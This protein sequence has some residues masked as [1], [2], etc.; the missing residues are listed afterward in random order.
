MIKQVA[1]VLLLGL[2]LT[3][4]KHELPLV[5]GAPPNVTPPTPGSNTICFQSSVL[6]IFVSN[7]AKSGCHDAASHEEGIV[8]DNYAGI[9]RG[10][11]ANDAAN[12]KYWKVIITLN[13]GDRMPPPPASPLSTAQKDSIYKW[14]MQGAQNTT[15]CTT[16]CDTAQFAYTSTIKPILQTNC[17][18]CHG[19][20]SPG[21]GYNLTDFNVLK[22]VALN[23]K[24][25]GSVKHAASY[26]AMPPVGKLPDCQITQIKKWIDAGTPNN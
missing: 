12:S 23:G 18:G 25:L 9:M 17:Y 19:T 5:N 26:V 15:N 22:T 1:L 16:G 20:L 2:F 3:S 21:G 11:R 10:I 24:L 7:C 4:C 8:L 14:I 6:P 13:N